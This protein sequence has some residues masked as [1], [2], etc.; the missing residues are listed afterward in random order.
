MRRKISE[1]KLP[2]IDTFLNQQTGILSSYFKCVPYGQK[3][4]T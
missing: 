3:F 2:R 1:L 4:E